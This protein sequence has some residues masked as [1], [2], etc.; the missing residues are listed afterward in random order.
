M[1][2]TARGHFENIVDKTGL[3]NFKRKPDFVVTD[4]CHFDI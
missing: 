1:S 2:F 3:Y 4:R